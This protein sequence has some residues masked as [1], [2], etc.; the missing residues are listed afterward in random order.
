M[1]R[2]HHRRRQNTRRPSGPVA[3][4]VAVLLAAGIGFTAASAYTASNTVPSTNIGVY[5]HSIGAAQ[6]EPAA[7]TGTVTTI[8]N[9]PTGGTSFNIPGSG[10]LVLGTSGNDNVH[11][12]T[13]GY[14][15]FLGGGPTSSNGDKF[16]GPGSGGDQCIIATSDNTGNIQH[17]TIVQHS[18]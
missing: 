4:A 11:G 10:N 6:L 17:C 1:R 7:C 5:T 14:N 12:P 9:V 15:C 13:N 16:N 3:L 8:V 18:P 2:R